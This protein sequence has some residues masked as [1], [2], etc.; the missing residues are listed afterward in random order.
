MYKRKLLLFNGY[1]A[2]YGAPAT[3]SNDFSSGSIPSGWTYSRSSA[4]T[5]FVGGTLTSFSSGTPRLV[6]GGGILLEPASQNW[7]SNPRGEG[8]AAPALPT[9]WNN[10]NAGSSAQITWTKVGNGTENGIPYTD[11]RMQGTYV[12]GTVRFAFE[13]IAVVPYAPSAGWTQI[14]ACFSAFVKVVGGSISA[15]ITTIQIGYAGYNAAL[16]VQGGP[17]MFTFTPPASTVP[18]KDCRFSNIGGSIAPGTNAWVRPQ[19]HFTVT[20]G[21]VDLTLRIGAPQFEI[22]AYAPSSP[23]LPAVGTPASATRAGDF[24]T[25]PATAAQSWFNPAASSTIT[26]YIQPIPNTTTWLTAWRSPVPY[27]HD[28]T[29][30]NVYGPCMI[31]SFTNPT[32]R[33]QINGGVYQ[34][35]SSVTANAPVPPAVTRYGFGTDGYYRRGAIN[36]VFDAGG[37]FG[38]IGSKP[39]PSINELALCNPSVFVIWQPLTLVSLP[40]I[41][42]KFEYYPRLLSPEELLMETALH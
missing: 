33:L 42:R 35:V 41:L 28:G 20:A 6:D 38:E 36:G 4:G 14:L 21:A 37:Y 10:P 11:I 3:I 31:S 27:F 18:L 24:L 19:L 29:E 23:M 2:G 25:R 16:A 26:E 30:N 7:V 9:N 8:A 15:N 12:S 32:G 40:Y 1:N 39:L 22:N 5:G 34:A 17:L 13:N